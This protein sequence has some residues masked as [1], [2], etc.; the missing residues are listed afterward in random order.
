MKPNKSP[1]QTPA[2][3]GLSILI[4]VVMV[5]VIPDRA[6]DSPTT[7]TAS[8]ALVGIAKQATAVAPVPAL[9][10]KPLLRP[11]AVSLRSGTHE[12]TPDDATSLAVIEKLAHNPDEFIRLVEENSRI[13]R[14]QL[15]YRNETV[16]MLLERS[17]G[18]PLKSF[19]LPGLDGREVE[20]EVV[21]TR[22][23]GLTAG[24]VLGRVKGHMN[25]MVSIGFSNGCESFNVMLPDEGYFLT[26][27]A[28]EPGEVLVKEIDPNEYA[29]PTPCHPIVTK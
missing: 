2:A 25:S 9:S 21:E 1:F 5:A 24:T 23:N 27:D 8:P 26:A 16:P 6:D 22:L 28:R 17:G 3:V 7:A 4:L 11:L 15:V 29:P 19:T 14:R 12:W 18:Q 20:V 13:K 10:D